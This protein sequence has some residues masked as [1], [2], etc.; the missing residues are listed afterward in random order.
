MEST[1]KFHRPDRDDCGSVTVMVE[2]EKFPIEWDRDYYAAVTRYT[3]TPEECTGCNGVGE[4][5]LLDGSKGICPK[6]GGEGEIK[7]S[8]RKYVVGTF[9]LLRVVLSVDGAELM[10]ETKNSPPWTGYLIRISSHD[11]ATMKLL[12]ECGDD[13]RHLYDDVKSAADEAEKLNAQTRG[14]GE[15]DE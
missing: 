7:S 2:G 10:L 6:C 15:D 12:Q 14:E 9:R 4:I 8:Q 3:Y 1:I 5:N 11:F 13:V